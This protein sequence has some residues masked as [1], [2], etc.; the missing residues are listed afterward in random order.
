MQN[1]FL[2]SHE[3]N[4]FNLGDKHGSTADELKVESIN[5][6]INRI[7]KLIKITQ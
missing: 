2:D 6:E 1:Q 3:K 4:S 5:E 7:N